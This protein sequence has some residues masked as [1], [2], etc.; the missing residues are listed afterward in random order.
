MPIGTFLDKEKPPTPEDLQAALG[1]VYPLWDRLL[2]FIETNY[3]IPGVL[4]YGGKKYGWN[5]WYRKSG[6]TL[7]TLYPQQD[8]FVAQVVLGR[9]QAEKTAAL[10][11]GEKVRR[12]VTETP[13]LHDGTWLFIP[14]TEETDVLD[15]ERLLLLKRR[16]VLPHTS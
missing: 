16:P 2:R 12:L 4:S 10:E 6:K 13:Q 14:V 8:G 5:L 9:E 15:V 11:L 3:Q 1:S 7:T